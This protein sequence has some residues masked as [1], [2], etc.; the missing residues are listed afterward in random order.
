M[1]AIRPLGDRGHT[2]HVRHLE[3]EETAIPK[4][5]MNPGKCPGRRRQMLKDVPRAD[6]VIGVSGQ[7]HLLNETG[8]DVDRETTRRRRRDVFRRL[9]PRDSKSS[10]RLSFAEKVPAARA[11]LE[12]IAALPIPADPVNAQPRLESPS[13]FIV[14]E[15]GASVGIEEV[16]IRVQRSQ[17]PF[18]SIEIEQEV[19]TATQIQS[20]RTVLMRRHGSPTARPTGHI[21][22]GGDPL[23]VQDKP[24]AWHPYILSG[25]GAIGPR[26]ENDK[27]SC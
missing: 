16:V 26:P 23:V 15:R 10:G 21:R 18:R 6:K 19:A 24:L 3:E 27:R 17:L 5:A 22:R 25:A 13:S 9:E 20:K 11:D 4:C 2:S 12:Q 1:A 7:R 14:H 8:R